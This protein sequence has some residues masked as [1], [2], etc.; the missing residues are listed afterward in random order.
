MDISA[1]T[2]RA[3]TSEQVLPFVLSASRYDTANSGRS[4]EDV[5]AECDA[6]VVEQGGQH[7]AGLLLR[8]RGNEIYV[9][10]AAGGK[11]NLDMSLALH[12]L[13]FQKK[14]D[15][16][17]SVSF[18]TRRKGLVRKAE[19]LGYEIEGYILRKRIKNG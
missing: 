6:Y 10:A 3:A 12:R 4:A 18:T 9:V 17:E 19:K 13:I 16:I 14:A 1:L 5:I 2:I 7:V 8:R 11:K 15:D